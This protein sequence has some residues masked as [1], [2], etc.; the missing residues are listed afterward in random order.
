MKQFKTKII[1]IIIGLFVIGLLSM[2]TYQKALIGSDFYIYPTFSFFII[3]YF[4][5]HLRNKNEKNLKINNIVLEYI[6]KTIFF[7]NGIFLG[8]SSLIIVFYSFNSKSYHLILYALPLL[9]Y[10]YI[11]MWLP[12]N[13]N[14]LIKQNI[15]AK[16]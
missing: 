6:F 9:Y 1:I 5:L 13:Y 10:A 4:C 15:A 3:L 14:D 11:V 8:M 16:S 2:Y 12:S 7:L